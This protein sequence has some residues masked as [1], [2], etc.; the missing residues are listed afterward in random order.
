M[1]KRYGVSRGFMITVM[2]LKGSRI[3]FTNVMTGITAAFKG[4]LG[5]G[6]ID[7]R[8]Y[9]RIAGFE[10]HRLLHCHLRFF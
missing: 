5:V 6:V 10:L 7:P 1:I 3:H 8:G 2:R 4:Q 9:G